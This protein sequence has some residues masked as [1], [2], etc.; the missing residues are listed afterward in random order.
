MYEYSMTAKGT[1]NTATARSTVYPR[2]AIDSLYPST[3]CG[4]QVPPIPAAPV[5]HPTTDGS[6]THR[7]TT[8][9]PA[10]STLALC[11]VSLS[12]RCT[13]MRNRSTLMMRRMDTP[14]RTNSQYSMMEARQK[15]LPKLQS[16]VAT[17]TAVKG[18]QSSESIMSEKANVAS[19]RLIAERMA[20]FW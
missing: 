7:L 6:D 3:H 5:L 14:S 1:K 2:S 20:G 19:R 16:A 8:Q 15:P 18:M 4:A 9:E 10:I 12:C 13:M 17:V 11:G